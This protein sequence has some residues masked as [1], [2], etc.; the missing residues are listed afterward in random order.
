MTDPSSTAVPNN[1]RGIGL[2]RALV[3]MASFASIVLLLWFLFIAQQDPY[4]NAVL[5]T[6]GSIQNG[7]ILFRM[8]CAG[9]HGIEAQGLV[10]PKLRNIAASRRDS[11]L[12]KQVVSGKTPPMP[13]FELEAESMADLL[14]YLHSLD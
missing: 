9:C 7:S 1:K 8:N 14:A 2:V 11:D 4:V 12:I 13:S 6:N 3:L 10:G 5:N